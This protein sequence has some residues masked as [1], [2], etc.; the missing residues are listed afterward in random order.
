MWGKLKQELLDGTISL[1]VHSMKYMPAYSVRQFRFAHAWKRED[2]RDVLNLREAVSL[3]GTSTACCD[4]HWKPRRAF[5]SGFQRVSMP[6]W[7]YVGNCIPEIKKKMLRNEQ[8]D[9]ELVLGGAGG[10]TAPAGFEQ[11]SCKA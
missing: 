1:A 3:E 9:G 11:T 7:N 4:R 6:L 5:S 2:P 8:L 10:D